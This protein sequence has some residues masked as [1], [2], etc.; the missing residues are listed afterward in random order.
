MPSVHKDNSKLEILLAKIFS[1]RQKANQMLSAALG[2]FKFF[3]LK[4][5]A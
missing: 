3:L 2:K 1:L 4:K 5:T